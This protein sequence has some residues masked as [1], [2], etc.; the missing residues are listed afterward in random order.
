MKSDILLN[1]PFFILSVTTF[2]IAAY[3][4]FLIA[5]NAYKKSFPFDEK[6]AKHVFIFGLITFIF[7]LFN[8]S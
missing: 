3:P 2:E 1:F 8:S 7:S 6:S 5:P 4:T